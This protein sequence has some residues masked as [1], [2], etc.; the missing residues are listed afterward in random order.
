M[1]KTKLLTFTPLTYSLYNLTLLHQM[2]LSFLDQNITGVILDS[3]FSQ[4]SNVVH[5]EILLFKT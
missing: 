1:F 3:S 5:Q 4:S 2:K